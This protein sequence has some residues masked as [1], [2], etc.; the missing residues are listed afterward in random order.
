MHDF[1]K[2]DRPCFE[3]AESSRR[4]SSLLMLGG[5]NACSWLMQMSFS[6]ITVAV[7]VVFPKAA[8][9]QQPYPAASDDLQPAA[10]KTFS[11][12]AAPPSQPNDPFHLDFSFAST[13]VGSGDVKFQG[14]TAA[15]SDGAFSQTAD[16]RAQISMNDQW[17][18]LLDLGSANILE[19]SVAGAPVPAQINTLTLQPG[20]EYLVNPRCTFSAIIGPALYNLQ[21]LRGSD[22]GLCGSVWVNYRLNPDM[23]FVLGV[24]FNPSRDIPVL[25][26]GGVHWQIQPDLALDLIVPKPRVVYKVASGLSVF[27]GGELDLITFRTDGDI[28]TKTGVAG[29]NNALGSYRDIRVGVGTEYYLNPQFSLSLEGGYSVGREIDYSRIDSKAKFDSAAY[30]QV[31]LKVHF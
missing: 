15:H 7:S 11:T 26:V 6:F 24:N 5:C 8:L 14:N 17:S 27:A 22:V 10:A 31:G 3:P 20:L 25:P 4:R 16:L 13:Y 12:P 21:N 29:F 30:L 28:E 9:A 2:Q 18:V 23:N 19:N 1:L